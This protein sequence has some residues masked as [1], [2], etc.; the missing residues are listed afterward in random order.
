MKLPHFLLPFTGKTIA[1]MRDYV[2]DAWEQLTRE[3]NGLIGFG[4]PTEGL[5]NMRGAWYEG[6]TPGTADTDFTITHNLGYIPVGW[7]VFSIDK[8]GILY[9]GSVAWTPSDITL[10]CNA[11]SATI[12]I[13]I[14]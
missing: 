7:L 1:D 5:E 2:N 14:H 6:V 12:V 13:F 8:A 9:K 3:I 4:T 10:K 11:T